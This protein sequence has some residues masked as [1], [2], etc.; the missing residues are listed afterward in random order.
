MAA[1]ETA[2]LATTRE[3][4]DG[5]ARKLKK[6]PDSWIVIVGYADGEPVGGETQRRQ[7]AAQRAVNAKSYLVEQHEI[8]PS[9]IEPRVG[10]GRSG[11]AEIILVPRR[12]TLS[13][14]AHSPWLQDTMLV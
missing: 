4:L 13:D 11:V 12:S 7:V 5:V 3:I 10:S 8:D 14:P 2:L 9:R 6:A 1:S